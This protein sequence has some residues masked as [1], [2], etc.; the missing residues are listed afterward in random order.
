MEVPANAVLLFSM[1]GYESQEIP[2]GTQEVIN[3]QLKAGSAMIDDVVVVAFGKQRK[4]DVIGAVTQVRPGDL[5]VPSSNLT[6]ALAGR[7]AGVI[8]YQRSGEPDK[9]MQTFY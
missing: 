3:V 7:I 8:A 2:I 4:Q 5:K 9:I 1:V 6:T